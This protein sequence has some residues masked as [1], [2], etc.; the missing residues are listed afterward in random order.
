MNHIILV[1]LC[2]ILSIFIIIAV[3]LS[4]Q[5]IINNTNKDKAKCEPTKN[6][7]QENKNEKQ[8]NYNSYTVNFNYLPVIGMDSDGSSTMGKI[9]FPD[10]MIIPYF[11]DISKVKQSEWVVCDG[12]NGSP[13]L[14][15]RFITGAAFDGTTPVPYLLMKKV[16]PG[17]FPNPN[18]SPNPNLTLTL[19]LGLFLTLAITLPLL[20]QMVEITE[21]HALDHVDF[22]YKNSLWQKKKWLQ[23]RK[24]LQTNIC[25]QVYLSCNFKY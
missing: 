16:N 3:I 14:T 24:I 9:F 5:L 18:P 15:G 22:V 4:S 25:F 20:C 12:S 2:V 8:E 17:P 21:E 13:K 6:E 19:T 23:T 7:K 1:S 10:G 11:G